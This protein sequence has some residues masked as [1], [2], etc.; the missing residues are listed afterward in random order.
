MC[1]AVNK[2]FHQS[3]RIEYTFTKQSIYMVEAL[4]NIFQSNSGK[5]KYILRPAVV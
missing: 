3:S 4:Y 2:G 5:F 1:I